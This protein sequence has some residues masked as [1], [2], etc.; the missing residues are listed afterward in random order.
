MLNKI[1]LAKASK[2]IIPLVISSVAFYAATNYPELYT[3]FCE[4]K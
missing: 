3:S 1:M 2:I 4:V